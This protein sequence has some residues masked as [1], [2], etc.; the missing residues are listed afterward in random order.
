MD[1]H[2]VER[3]AVLLHE[4]FEKHLEV[5]EKDLSP[6]Q[7]GDWESLPD[8]IKHRYR[9]CARAVIADRAAVPAT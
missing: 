3:I 2:E 4:T 9:A 7:Y 5:V 6:K 1:E 8:K